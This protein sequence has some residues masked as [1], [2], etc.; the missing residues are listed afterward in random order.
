MGDHLLGLGTQAKTLGS[1]K[2][3]L[4][5]SLEHSVTNTNLLTNTESASVS[6]SKGQIEV[7]GA[8]LKTVT[9]SAHPN[10]KLN[11]DNYR[12]YAVDSIVYGVILS[13]PVSHMQVV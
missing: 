5:F 3:S 8:Q 6:T 12:R 7:A 2:G 13:Q 10:H 4:K 1:T 9:N 11:A